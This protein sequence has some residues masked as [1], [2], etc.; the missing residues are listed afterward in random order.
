MSERKQ[1]FGV[2]MKE[3]FWSFFINLL[4]KHLWWQGYACQ[5][6]EDITYPRHFS[7]TRNHLPTP[8]HLQDFLVIQILFVY[9]E[10]WSTDF[11]DPFLS[12]LINT[13]YACI[14]F[15]FKHYLEFDALIRI[16]VL[17]HSTSN[18]LWCPVLN[19]CPQI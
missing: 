7:D 13:L 1:L 8:L 3:M 14:C 5:K 2:F 12:S 11:L 15:Y 19:L 18:A 4:K 6:I 10:R 17:W 9:I 16:F